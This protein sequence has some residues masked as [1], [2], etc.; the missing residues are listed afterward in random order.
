MNCHLIQLNQYVN[1]MNMVYIRNFISRCDYVERKSN[2][3][4]IQ[5]MN[6]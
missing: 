2:Q 4:M 6:P 5:H 3:F 1:G